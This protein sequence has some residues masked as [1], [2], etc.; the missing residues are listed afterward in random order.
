MKPWKVLSSS[1]AFRDR[2]VKLRTDTLESPDGKILDGYHTLETADWVNIIA[3]T[4]RDEVVLVEQYRPSIGRARLELP[5]GLVDDGEGPE[6][7][8]R[9]ELL[10]ETGYA[11][12]R[13]LDLGRL[14]AMAA[15]MNSAF[16]T[17]IALGVV[18]QDRQRL[19]EHEDIKVVEVPWSKF[20]SDLP[21]NEGNQMASLMMLHLHGVRS[22]DPAI[23]RLLLQ[24]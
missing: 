3:L 6:E 13:W 23:R 24:Y 21:L 22:K 2:W 17:F 18:R 20:I 9:R 11:G 4:E 14:D 12:G 16:H 1:Y 10:E 5:G 8:A 19:D 15:R 7:A